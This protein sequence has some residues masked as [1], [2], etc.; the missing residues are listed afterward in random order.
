MKSV[1]FQKESACYPQL[2]TDLLIQKFL[3]WAHFTIGSTTE[4]SGCEGGTLIP[5]NVRVTCHSWHIPG[6]QYLCQMQRVKKNICMCAWQAGLVILS[7]GYSGLPGSATTNSQELLASSLG[8]LHYCNDAVWYKTA[9]RGFTLVI[10][11]WS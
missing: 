7:V 9:D 11:P 3:P 2:I 4:R 8:L 5:S 10:F 6:F 1:S